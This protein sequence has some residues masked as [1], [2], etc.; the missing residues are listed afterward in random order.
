MRRAVVYE[1]QLGRDLGF[2]IMEG[3]RSALVGVVAEVSTNN[4]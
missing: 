3:P 2:E 1:A 4:T